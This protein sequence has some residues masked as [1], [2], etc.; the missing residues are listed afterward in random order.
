MITI[1]KQL[2]LKSNYGLVHSH[3]PFK[4]NDIEQHYLL[5]LAK[6]TFA[7]YAKK[8]TCSDQREFLL[9]KTGISKATKGLYHND[10]DY[11]YHEEIYAYYNKIIRNLFGNKFNG[12]YFYLEFVSARYASWHNDKG[13]KRRRTGDFLDGALLWVYQSSN[14]KLLTEDGDMI[15]KRNNIYY[16]DDTK[17]HAF[18]QPRGI[19][20]PPAIMI[21]ITFS[22]KQL[23]SNAN[24][25]FL[26]LDY[27]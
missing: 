12:L 27:D 6:W 25:N 22:Q 21:G 4:K 15:M 9:K 2:N 24:N 20:K 8:E 5:R 16:F 10:L 7:N 1:K 23:F 18:H 3:A 14:H 26:G 11:H 19:I 13:G 17:E